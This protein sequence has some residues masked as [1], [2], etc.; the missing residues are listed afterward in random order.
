[1]LEI[2]AG[3]GAN[4][5]YYQ[6][7]QRVVATEPD[8]FMLRR[9]AQRAR[10]ARCPIRLCQ[11]YAE[12]L[13]FPDRAFDTVVSTLVLC[14]VVDPARSLAEIKRVLRPSGT[15]RFIEHVRGHGMLGWVQDSVTPVWRR[16]GAGCH[17]NRRTAESIAA[18]GFA[19]V[20]LE[21]RPLA[22][23]PLI[24]GVAAPR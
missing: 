8:P 6:A 13:P 12:A 4:F 18:A 3:T 20:E 23:T 1:V 10:A 22:V 19:I 2:G 5:R 16:V 14:S 15:F 24:I 21:E 11:C 9:A 17:P 7:A